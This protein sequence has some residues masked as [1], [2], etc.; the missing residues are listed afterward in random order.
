MKPY[1]GL[2][3][4]PKYFKRDSDFKLLTIQSELDSLISQFSKLEKQ[5]KDDN[6]SNLRDITLFKSKY[7]YN[8]LMGLKYLKLTEELKVYK[9][10]FGETSTFLK[11]NDELENFFEEHKL[12]LL[13]FFAWLENICDS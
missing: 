10:H 6:F 9:Y 12:P 11:I 4:K 8:K 5:K 13:D 1:L 7:R 3:P 2:A